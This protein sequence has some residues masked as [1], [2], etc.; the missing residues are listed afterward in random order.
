MPALA[1]G[2]GRD[3]RLASRLDFRRVFSNGRKLHGRFFV[4]W[5]LLRRASTS[6]RLGL[7]V[8]AKVGSAVR[9]NRLKR[10]TREVFRHPR[11][12]LKPG[13]DL[14]V[15]LRPGCDWRSRTQAE[16]A[17][18]DACQKAGLLA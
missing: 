8:S 5:S 18:L 1:N 7:S 17:L 6:P 13:A 9:R 10:L 11:Q 15:A 12:T 3:A 4:L 14:I 16:A 2:F